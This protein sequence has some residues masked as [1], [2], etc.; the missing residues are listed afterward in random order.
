MYQDLI[1]LLCINDYVFKQRR[2]GDSER[3]SGK[4]KISSFQEKEN[5]NNKNRNT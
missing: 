1:S 4:N 5:N 3:R 2:V